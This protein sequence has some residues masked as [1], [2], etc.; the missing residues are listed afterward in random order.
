M[1]K[2]KKPRADSKLKNLPEA[3]MEAIWLLMHPADTE[4]QAWTLDAVAVHVQDTY[5]FSVALSTLSEWHAWYAL[6]RRMEMAAQRAN[7]T[8]IELA[9][10]SDLSPEDIERVA[11]TVFTAETLERGDVGG[12]VQLAKLRLASSKQ[13]IERE[14][15]AASAKTKIEAGLDAL[16]AEIQGNPKALKLFTDLQEAVA[17]A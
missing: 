8:S 14:K 11:Q 17:K 15:I 5:R 6:K 13:A 16:L 9:R 4:T 10:N 12:Y 2:I 1:I 7:Q 3:E